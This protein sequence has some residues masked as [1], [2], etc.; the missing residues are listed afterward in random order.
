MK[1]DESSVKNLNFNIKTRI[2]IKMANIKALEGKSFFPT[3]ILNLMGF[4]GFRVFG[5]LGI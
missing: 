2:K 5:V 3:I 4:W 1:F